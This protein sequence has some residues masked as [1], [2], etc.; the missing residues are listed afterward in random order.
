[1][2]EGCPERFDWEFLKWVAEQGLWT[3]SLC[4][5]RGRGKA[6]R[7]IEQVA[8]EKQAFHIKSRREVDAFLCSVN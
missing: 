6:M 2:H 4:R 3:V 7:L 5:R 8:A 1:M